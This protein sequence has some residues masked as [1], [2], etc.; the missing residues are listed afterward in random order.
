M[1]E[2]TA[3]DPWSFV[4]YHSFN[5]TVLSCNEQPTVM[6]ASI[7]KMTRMADSRLWD[8]ASARK[9]GQVRLKAPPKSKITSA[10]FVNELHEQM[11]VL[12]EMSGCSGLTEADKL[13]VD[14]GDIHVLA[15]PSHEPSQMQTI[16]SFLALD[17]NRT[18]PNFSLS[19]HRHL[20]TSW[21]RQS[22]KLCVAGASE[23]I[24]VWDCSAERCERASPAAA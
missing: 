6:C 15:G 7:C 2:I 9:T 19:A 12:A 3:P 16:S 1:K 17:V 22:G 8:W 20:R 23:M 11:V 24:N 4:C 18:S 5:S 14:T 21:W 13:T 10:R